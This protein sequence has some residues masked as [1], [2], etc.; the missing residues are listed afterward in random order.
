QLKPLIAGWM[1]LPGYATK[2]R[3]FFELAFQQTQISAADFADQTFPRQIGLNN[4]TV[5]LLVQNTQ[6][7]FARTMMQLIDDG[8]P[9]MDAAITNRLMMTTALKELYAFLDGW[10]VDDTGKVTD[11]FKRDNPKLTLTVEAAQGPIPIAD[12]LDPASPNYM[13]WYDPDV[14]TAVAA[15]AGCNEDPIVYPATG[16]ALH[17]LL[18]GSLE[19]RK[20]AAGTNC[21]PTGGT[22]A[23]P[24]LTTGDFGDWSM[25][26]LRPPAAGEA[27]TKFYDLPALRTA[28]ELV[29][30]VPRVGFFSTPAFFANWQTNI[31]NQMRVTLNQTL[32]VALGSSVDG[33]DPTLTPG[34]PGLDAAHAG[35]SNCLYCHQTLDPLRSI[36]A[37]TFSW[38]YHSQLDPAFSAQK[39]MFSFRGVTQPVTSV[40]DL[41]AQLGQ[42]PL[43]PSAWAQ[44]LCYYVNSTA[45]D[46]SD[47]EFMRVVGVFRDSG[48]SWNALVQELLSSPL[49]TN[50]AV[51]KTATENGEIVAVS[52]RDHFCAALN[53][54]LGF[55]DACGLDLVSKRQLQ[56]AIP[57]IVAGLP[58]DGYG[59][60]STAPVLPNQSTLFYRAGTENI[61]AGIAAAV[62]DVAAA[63]QLPGVITW[64][65]AD[66]A[67]A[68]GDFVA[69]VIGL[70]P[71]DPRAA[72]ATALLNAHFAAAVKQGAT[73]SAALKSTFI[74]A[75]LAPSAVSIGL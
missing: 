49:S 59:R 6:Q 7:S 63:K 38:N 8:R 15:V 31:S 36:F 12:T 66:P 33:T 48:Y 45:C 75:C 34:N 1:K 9:L 20:N 57:Q 56:G 40:T 24:Q 67:T 41:G 50:A 29:L 65:S 74:T 68:I 51:T 19:G 37:A 17:F 60:G 25:V 43:F 61:C 47:P 64:S 21:P 53:N 62:I 16:I 28:T 2:M 54:R 35:S 39:G 52:R 55:A 30:S 13:H 32:I 18:Y 27:T 22:A 26:T 42:H 69:T 5:P 58:S 46:D 11:Y 73:A 72:P 4:T 10:E 71:S 14:A 70:V 3:R 23:A 44:K